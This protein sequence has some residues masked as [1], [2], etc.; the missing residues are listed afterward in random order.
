M[1]HDAQLHLR[2]VGGHETVPVP[3]DKQPAQ[4]PALVFADG[5]VLQIRLGRRQPAR[6]GQHLIELCVHDAVGARHLAQPVYIRRVELG[7]VPEPY[8]FGDYG[9]F[10]HYVREHFRRRGFYAAGGSA[11]AFGVR[12]TEVVEQHAGQLLGRVYVEL[13]AAQRVYLFGA[14]LFV[15]VELLFQLGE[16]AEVDEKAFFLHSVQHVDERKL[17]IAV[18]P[19]HMLLFEQRRGFPRAGHKRGGGVILGHAQRFG[20]TF[21]R[22]SARPAGKIFH[23]RDVLVAAQRDAESG[24]IPYVLFGVVYVFFHARILERGSERGEYLAFGRVGVEQV[25]VHGQRIL[26]PAV[27]GK[28]YHLAQRHGEFLAAVR[29]H[30]EFSGRRERDDFCRVALRRRLFSFAEQFVSAQKGFEIHFGEKLAY[31]GRER[32]RVRHV[33]QRH[34]QRAVGFYGGELIRHFAR[35]PARFDTLGQLAAYIA[36]MFVYSPRAAVFAEQ[37]ERALFAH[38]RH[39][40]DVVR[41]VAGKR[42]EVE[43]LR[44]REPHALFERRR[45]HDLH[46]ADAALG[47]QHRRGVVYELETVAVAGEDKRFDAV[48]LGE[49]TDDVVRFYPLPLDVL[50][51]HYVQHMLDHGHLHGQL[52]GHAAAGGLIA[53]VHLVP[54]G[55]RVHVESH[56]HVLRAVFGYHAHEHVRKA[57]YRAARLAFFRRQHGQRVVRAVDEAVAVYEYK[58]V[59]EFHS[60]IINRKKENVNTK[61]T[62]PVRIRVAPGQAPITDGRINSDE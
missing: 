44:R 48:G 29:R 51:T 7:D 42:L 41:R 2:V 8:D 13:F 47:E 53:V 3:R 60:C 12:Q 50:Y 17:E 33:A 32:E 22:R 9:M 40:G 35:F 11:H 30:R 27:G 58:F 28:R 20:I 45:V 18:Q 4:H 26:Q 19:G 1:R 5:N 38:A 21:R 31:L 25:L 52:V 14:F 37:V 23:E 46:F 59:V 61:E 39:A 55:R 49:R 36:E 24:E 6:R 15:G 62:R 16:K 56:R 34:V 57:V 43:N 54:E 10:A